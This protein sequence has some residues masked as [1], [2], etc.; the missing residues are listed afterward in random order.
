VARK[1]ELLARIT[2]DPM[3]MVG[4]PT[5]RGLRVTLEQILRALASGVAEAELLAG[6][7]ELE[8][9]DIRAALLYASEL[10]SEKQVYPIRAAV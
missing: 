4:K 8:P 9:E 10:V 3:V 7:P 2:A 1:A 6:Y 5:V